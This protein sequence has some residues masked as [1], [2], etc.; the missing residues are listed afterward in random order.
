MQL[1]IIDFF[2]IVA[3]A[4]I[5]S[6]RIE[7]TEFEIDSITVGGSLCVIQLIEVRLFPVL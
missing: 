4:R 2:D 1:T 3:R 7:T 6:F 5:T